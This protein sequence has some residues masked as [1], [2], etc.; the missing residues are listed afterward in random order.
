MFQFAFYTVLFF[1][2]IVFLMFYSPLRGLILEKVMGLTLELSEYTIPG[3]RLTFLVAIF[4]DTLR[5]CEECFQ[6]CG[7]PGPSRYR[8]D[9]D[10][11]R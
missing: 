3:V 4:W 10:F 2:A 9:F 7:V 5:C 8:R 11:W 1:V 6:P